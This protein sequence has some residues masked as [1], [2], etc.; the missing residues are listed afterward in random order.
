ME[1]PNNAATRAGENTASVKHE[2]VSFQRRASACMF[3]RALRVNIRRNCAGGF[4][5]PSPWPVN[6]R[7]FKE[8]L[9]CYTD[10]LR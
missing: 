3:V 8:K 6:A 7:P 5:H 1:D 2:T 4:Q 9:R 10:K